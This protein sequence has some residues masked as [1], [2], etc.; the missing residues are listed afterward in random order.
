VTLSDPY[1]LATKKHISDLVAR[2]GKSIYMINL[3]KSNEHIAREIIL[4]EEFQQSIATVCTELS[5]S[6]IDVAYM[7]FDMKAQLKQDKE[8]FVDKCY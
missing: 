6:D 2:Y 3:V 1:L 4:A 5:K 8:E 7:H